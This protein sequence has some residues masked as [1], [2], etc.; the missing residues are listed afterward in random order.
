MNPMYF[1]AWLSY[2]RQTVIAFEIFHSLQTKQRQNFH[3]M[4]LKLDMSKA[5]DRVEWSFLKNLMKSMQFPNHFTSLIMKRISSVTF[6]ILINGIPTHTF[7]PTRGILQEDPLSPLPL[8]FMRWR[9]FD[10]VTH[11]S[12]KWNSQD[13]VLEIGPRYPTSYLLMTNFYLLEQMNCKLLN[14]EKYS[15][16]MGTVWPKL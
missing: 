4:A 9:S 7:V 10:T 14:W 11:I 1:F 3:F 15:H 13:I 8:H 6:S 16:Y 2:F 5:F 12:R